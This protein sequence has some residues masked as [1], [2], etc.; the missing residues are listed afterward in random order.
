MPSARVVNHSGCSLTHGWS[1]EALQREVQRHL[2]AQLPGPW[3]RSSSKS[4]NVPRSGWMASWPPSGEP[5]AHGDPGSPGCGVEGVV[6]ALAVRGPDRV[7]RRQVHHVEAHL[8][9]RVQPVRGGPEG[10]GHRL[11]AAHRVDLDPFRAGEE[12][13]PGPVQGPLPVHHQRHPP[14]PGHQLAQRVGGQHPDD[15]R[16]AGGGQPVPRRQLGVPQQPGHLGQ[17]GPD[18]VRGQR[19]VAGRLAWPRRRAAAPGTTG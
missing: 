3:R 6:A 5:M 2:H 17:R 11:A 9:H 10:A 8:G 1:G 4:S 13:V 18:H 16:L 19:L 14:G 15:L 7:D 12:L